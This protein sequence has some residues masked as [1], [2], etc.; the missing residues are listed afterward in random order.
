[1]RTGRVRRIAHKHAAPRMPLLGRHLLAV[2]DAELDDPGRAA[3]QL[4]GHLVSPRPHAFGERALP[5]FHLRRRAEAPR[6]F[7]P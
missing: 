1:M 2:V 4:S 7:L 3:D 5:L 6:G